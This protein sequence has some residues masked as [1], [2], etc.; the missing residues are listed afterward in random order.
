VTKWPLQ[1]QNG[2]TEAKEKLL[3]IAITLKIWLE[4]VFFFVEFQSQF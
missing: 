1:L 3:H 2:N 4:A